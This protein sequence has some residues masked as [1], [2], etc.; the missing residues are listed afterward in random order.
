MTATSTPMRTIHG[1]FT[2]E[3]RSRRQSRLSDHWPA[4]CGC[5]LLASGFVALPTIARDLIA[6][7]SQPRP[8]VHVMDVR[9]MWL[10][11][12]GT[13]LVS[14]AALLWM[15]GLWASRVTHGAARTPVYLMIGF[16]AVC[17]LSGT[18]CFLIMT[19]TTIG[20][21]LPIALGLSAGVSSILYCLIGLLL[22][23]KTKG[24]SAWQSMI[25]F[26]TWFTGLSVAVCTVLETQA[27][28]F[29]SGLFWILMPTWCFVL[30]SVF[31]NQPQPAAN[32]RHSWTAPLSRLY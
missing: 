1:P 5:L 16:V 11:G 3:T 21:M 23:A 15:F 17:D 30:N 32:I 20:S 19:P 2:A 9:W 6:I 13:I 28:I 8:S 18:A 7:F 4:V 22:Q 10:T 24:L 27:M 25:G 26:S 29:A 14:M 31:R 12:W